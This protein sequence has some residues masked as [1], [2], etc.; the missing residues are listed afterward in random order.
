MS[1]IV[2]IR[3]FKWQH[4][5]SGRVECQRRCYCVCSDPTSDANPDDVRDATVSFLDRSTASVE[6]LY[7][8]L[9]LSNCDSR[10]TAPENLMGRREVTEML[11]DTTPAAYPFE[12]RVVSSRPCM[13]YALKQRTAVPFAR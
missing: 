5:R 1:H 9:R 4:E 13:S 3:Q 11:C 8:W 10:N 7:D 12:F 6:D 2:F